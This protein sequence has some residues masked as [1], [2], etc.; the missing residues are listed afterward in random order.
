MRYAIYGCGGYGREVGP[1]VDANIATLSGK[2]DVVFVSDTQIE[3]GKVINGRKVINFED[4]TSPHHSDRL[5]IVGIGKPAARR[6]I[7]ERCTAKGL[8]F[9]SVSSMTHRR[10]EDV[11]VGPG[12]IFSEFSMC[13]SNVRIG[14]HFH[15]NIYSYVAHDCVIGDFVTFAPRVCCNGRVEI[16]DD[17]YVGT[18]AVIR[19][20]SPDKPTIIGRGAVIGMGAVVTKDVPAGAVVVGN[21]ARPLSR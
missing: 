17:T 3:V 14:S 19:E 13:T 9:G 5:V 10:Y 8:R 6:S 2:P 21:P 1:L 18:G 15:C 4:L 20:G 11:S 7:V 16:G 12:A